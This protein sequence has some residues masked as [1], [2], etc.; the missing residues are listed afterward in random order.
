MLVWTV[1]F[2]TDNCLTQ[3]IIIR[4]AYVHCLHNILV[5]DGELT[6]LVQR[7][8]GYQVVSATCLRQSHCDY[9][10]KKYLTI[11]TG[12][13]SLMKYAMNFKMEW[14]VSLRHLLLSSFYPVQIEH[15]LLSRI[16]L[17]S[18]HITGHWYQ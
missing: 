7:C 16:V 4:P 1:T 18:V 12:S 14:Y 3:G 17:L 15:A 6:L 10:V 8:E 2:H 11:S 9:C 5:Q 13:D